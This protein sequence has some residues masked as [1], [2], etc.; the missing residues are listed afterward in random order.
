LQRRGRLQRFLYWI[1]GKMANRGDG[2]GARV[3]AEQI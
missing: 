1:Q 2:G 3:L